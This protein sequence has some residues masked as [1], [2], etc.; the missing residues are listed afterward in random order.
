MVLD[1]IFGF[2]LPF[3]PVVAVTIFAIIILV[4]I[5]IFYKIL[6]K[7]HEA[8]ELKEKTKELNRQMKEAQKAG[9]KDESNK[10]LSEM[11]RENS[12]LMRMT[13]KPMIVSFIIVIL[14]LPWPA[15]VYGDKFV[16]MENNAGELDF[17]GTK[18]QV[19]ATDNKISI[20]QVE[21]CTMPCTEKIGS[22]LFEVNQESDN[23]KFAPVIA[24]LP[25]SLPFVGNSLGW[26]GWYIL[27]S[28]PLAVLIRKFMKIY[29]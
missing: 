20:N 13:M 2:L 12:R 14:L 28:I 9:N 23:I 26:L 7:Q 22:M 15:G 3:D 11:M 25:V 5:N 17:Q 19:Q 8:K 10:L 1:V 27:T 4:L 24:L 29:V 21:L 16:K 6:I 18:Y